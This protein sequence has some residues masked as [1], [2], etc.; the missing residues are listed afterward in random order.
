MAVKARPLP[1]PLPVFNWTGCYIGAYVGGATQS[2]AVNATDPVAISGRFPLGSTYNAPGD[3]RF[4]YDL[5]S[6]VIGGGTLGCNW[7]GAGSPFVI[8]IEGEGG[9]MRL[10]ASV[11]EP[12]S[13][14]AG[15]MIASTKIGD[16]YGVI[17]GRA[18]F[19][20]DRVLIYGKAGV[21]FTNIGSSMTDTCAA[22]PCGP[23]TLAA[24]Y[25]NDHAFWVAGGGLEYALTPNWS[26]KSEYLFLGIDKSY[27]FCGSVPFAGGTYCSSHNVQG[28]HTGKFGINYHFG[29]PAA[30][31]Y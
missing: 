13:L 14:P 18:G 27:T 26:V 1:P 6:S 3:P 22:L 24:A 7:Q 5:D 15:D 2:R 11:V 21:G 10:R 8:G 29:G 23:G 31:R 28:V 12:F 4:S 25:S 9:Y 20:W 17:A 30:A 16:W 19:A